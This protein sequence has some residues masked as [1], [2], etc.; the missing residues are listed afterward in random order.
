[1]L[2]APLIAGNDLRNMKK[3]TIEILTN[4]EVIAV[5]QDSLGVQ[6][7]KYSD[8]EDG[9]EVWI[10]PLKNGDWAFCFLN[11][12][13]QKHKIDFDWSNKWISDDISKKTLDTK[14]ASYSIKDLWTK[15]NLGDT[16]KKLT[17]EIPSHDVLMVKLIK[18]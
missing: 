9:V 10:K 8:N 1:M 3:E 16:K 11:K 7:L 4:K 17:A 6:A 2:A 5:D 12:S 13:E 15:K 18:Q 14:E